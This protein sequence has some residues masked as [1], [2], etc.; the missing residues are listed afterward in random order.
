MKA[1]LHIHSTASDGKLSPKEIVELAVKKGLE[2]ISITDHDSVAGIPEAIEAAHSFS[3]LKLVPAVEMAADITDGELHILG[4]FIDF[5]HPQLL[6]ALEYQRHS[7]ETR[8]IKIISR[9]KELGIFVD[10]VRVREI[11]KGETLGRTHI[12]RAMVEAG[13]VSSLREAFLKYIGRGRPAYI[14]REGI[15]PEEIVRLII[16]VGGLPVI[17]HPLDTGL[18]EDGLKNLLLHLRKEGLVGLEAYYD[19]YSSYVKEKLASLAH[20]FGLIVTGGSDYHG[21]EETDTPIG[22]VEIPTKE[23]ERLLILGQK[24]IYVSR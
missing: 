12:A 17:A 20:S 2:V 21:W 24:R 5:S 10:F 7:R 8:M 9:L 23:I 15:S 3:H 19:G 6:K 11:A 22:E 16:N 14:P 18:T 4:Y 13:Y 1:D